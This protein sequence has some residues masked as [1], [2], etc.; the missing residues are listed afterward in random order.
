MMVLPSRMEPFGI[1]LIEAMACK[2]PVVAT[3]VGGI[4]EIVEH[5]MSGILVEPENPEA[6]TAGLRRVLTDHDLRNS[7]V[8]NGY[9]RSVGA[10]LLDPQRGR[11]PVGLR[12]PASVDPSLPFGSSRELAERRRTGDQLMPVGS[13]EF[14]MS[15]TDDFMRGASVSPANERSLCAGLLA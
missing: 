1:A 2:A 10:V 15:S 13:Y 8:E 7:I 6:L 11:L 9:A 3:K 5:E 12:V 4:P 14:I